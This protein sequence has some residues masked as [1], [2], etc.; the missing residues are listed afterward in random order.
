M[1]DSNFR[2]LIKAL[3]LLLEQ[4]RFIQVKTDKMTKPIDL[5]Q[6]VPLDS[7]PLTV[8]TALDQARSFQEKVCNHAT[9]TI[10]NGKAKLNYI[11]SFR[12][13]I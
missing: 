3:L 1:D 4:Q 9:V 6:T 7:N 5:N 12:D 8:Q 11:S 13:I 10:N 2:H